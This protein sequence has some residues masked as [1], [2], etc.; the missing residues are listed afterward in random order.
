V[1]PSRTSDRGARRNVSGNRWLAYPPISVPVRQMTFFEAVVIA[2]Q[3][4]AWAVSS[5]LN[6]W[7]LLTRTP[8]AKYL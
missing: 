1:N 5:P 6:S 7:Q 8:A 3:A 4:V 2:A